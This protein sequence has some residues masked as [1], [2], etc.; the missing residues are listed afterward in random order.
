LP[1]VAKL[2]DSS[3]MSSEL[4]SALADARIW[5]EK[6]PNVEHGSAHWYALNNFRAF[7]VDVEAAPSPEGIARAVYALNHHIV[8]QFE[9]SAPYCKEITFFCESIRMIGK[10]MER[11]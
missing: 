10:A 9:W 1:S 6:Q 7:L 4:N 11:A 8:D 3:D 5:L 2:P